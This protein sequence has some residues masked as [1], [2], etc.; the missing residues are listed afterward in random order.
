MSARSS[1][2]S[3][4]L[5]VNIS[6]VWHAS[7]C[8]S[9][10]Q[11]SITADLNLFS[12]ILPVHST[13]GV[14]YEYMGKC[15]CLRGTP[16]HSSTI[17]PIRKAVISKSEIGSVNFGFFCVISDDFT[18][19][20]HSCLPTMGSRFYVPPIHTPLHPSYGA[21]TNA[22]YTGSPGISSMHLIGSTDA[23]CSSFRSTSTNSITAVDFTRF[24]RDGSHP[25]T[26]IS[27]M[28][29]SFAAGMPIVAW[30]NLPVTE[31]NVLKYT[32]PLRL[33]DFRD[34]NISSYLSSV[35]SMQISAPLKIHPSTSCIVSY[36]PFTFSNFDSD[37]GSSLISFVTDCGGNTMWITLRI[38]R[39]MY[40]RRYYNFER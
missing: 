12:A 26:K 32:L 33:I 11:R 3:D 19:R 30:H 1:R 15:L 16:T 29:T 28:N 7:C 18:S 21:S 17:Q 8:S 13:V 39:D 25:S 27:V 36:R 31:M 22:I 4:I 37:I 40:S 9:S 38:A 5:S 2:I 24:T 14:L 6:D 20:L 35:S 23:S 34:F 10:A